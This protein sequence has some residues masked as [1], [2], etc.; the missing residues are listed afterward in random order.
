M[1]TAE[2]DAVTPIV[3]LQRGHRHGRVWLSLGSTTQTTVTLSGAQVGELT[4]ALPTAAGNGGGATPERGRSRRGP[5]ALPAADV[6]QR[7]LQAAYEVDT[8]FTR[9]QSTG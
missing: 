6:I 3:T 1:R 7:V 9:R 5:T 4:G 2:G 8:I